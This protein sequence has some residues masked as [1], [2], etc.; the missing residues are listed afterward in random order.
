MPTL[1]VTDPEA[2]LRDRAGSF[3]VTRDGPDG[4]ETL[5]QLPAHHVD[6]VVLIGGA[7]ATPDAVFL[8][9]DRRVA[10]AWVTRGGR[11][12]ARLVPAEPL[13]GEL[14]LAQYRAA[15]D[16]AG[17]LGRARAVVRAKVASAAAVLGRHAAN[18]AGHAAREGAARLAAFLDRAG[19]ADSLDTLRG[20]EGLAARDYFRALGECFRGALRFCGRARRPPPDPVNSLLSFGYTLVAA[21]LAGLL[22]ARGLDPA[23]GFYHT[24]RSGRAALAL[25]LLE[26][27]RHP[28]VDRFVLRACNREEL[29]TE[30]FEPD[31]DRPKGVRLTRDGQRRFFT[32]WEAALADP[33]P[34]AGGGPGAGAR[35]T[36]RARID[37]LAVGLRRGKAD[38]P[39]VLR[40]PH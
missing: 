12:R 39:F 13:D 15:S 26:E 36:W 14:R 20:V 24:S 31:P 28:V 17:S 19:A 8:C 23:V 6:G 32:A 2:T 3:V 33:L 4:R 29:R 38:E 40:G 34:P 30:H 7:R 16:P 11:V 22:T 10:V 1:Y 25:D 27:F 35:D 9:F 37:R 21:E 5:R 18:Y